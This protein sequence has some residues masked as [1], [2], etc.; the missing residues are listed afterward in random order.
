IGS[1]AG[2]NKIQ[3]YANFIDETTIVICGEALIHLDL[4]SAQFEHK[5]KAAM[6]TVDTN[7]VPSDKVDT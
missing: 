5:K 3:E 2:N 7:E 4:T 6:V 1:A